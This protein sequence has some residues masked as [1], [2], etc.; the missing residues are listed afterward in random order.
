MLFLIRGRDMIILTL[1]LCSIFILI[2]LKNIL[3]FFNKKHVK[4]IVSVLVSIV[5]LFLF[6]SICNF[7]GWSYPVSYFIFILLNLSV[8]ILISIIKYFIKSEHKKIIISI[9]SILAIILGAIS[10]FKYIIEN[11][12]DN[13]ITTNSNDIINNFNIFGISAGKEYKG[14]IVEINGI[15]I[16]MESPKDFKPL[17]DASCIYFGDDIH[18]GTKIVCYFDDIIVYNLEIGQKITVR[19]KFKKYSEYE[20]GNNI[21]FIKGK[22][23]E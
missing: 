1:L 6:Y 2:I 16:Y 9:F 21:E 13:I 3:L 22:I 15:I 11:S 12:Q 10:A 20:Y 4:I 7:M 23:I 18:G 19:C 5:D 8:I 14:K 17:W